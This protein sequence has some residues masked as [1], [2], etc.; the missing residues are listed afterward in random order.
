METNRSLFVNRDTATSARRGI[1]LTD[2]GH[3]LS[4]GL[5]AGLMP[6]A[7]G[8]WGSLL[9]VPL[10]LVLHPYGRLAYVVVIA[11]LFAAGVYLAGRTARA[12][13]V[14]DHSAIVIDEVVGM[15]VT[16][17]AADPGWISIPVGFA[18]FRLFD[19]AKPWPVRWIDQRVE[20]GMGIMLDDVA[21]GLMAAAVLQLLAAIP[22]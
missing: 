12:L 10:F 8:T 18:L 1:L 22:T 15:L 20:G 2:P 16:W 3:L 17:V 4:L 21:A 7:P 11:G 9:A 6:K 19:I 5:G 13:G 14:H